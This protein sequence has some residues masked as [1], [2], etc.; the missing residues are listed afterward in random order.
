MRWRSTPPSLGYGTALPNGQAFLTW[1][2]NGA[3]LYAP[4]PRWRRLRSQPHFALELASDGTASTNRILIGDAA[5]W[6]SFPGT[7]NLFA[8]RC[9]AMAA[10]DQRRVTEVKQSG[11]RPQAPTFSWGRTNYSVT[12]STSTNILNVSRRSVDVNQ[13]RL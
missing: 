1:A 10:V 5:Q 2:T 7:S 11:Q 3:G 4:D 12:F 8:G 13:F 6:N 9:M